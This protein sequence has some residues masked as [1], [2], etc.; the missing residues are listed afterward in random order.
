M[1]IYFE[2]DRSTAA[3]C[4]VKSV[5]EV[6][7]TFIC[8]VLSWHGKKKKTY[9]ETGQDLKAKEVDVWRI[10]HRLEFERKVDIE[11]VHKGQVLRVSLKNDMID[12]TGFVLRVDAGV[13]F[14]SQTTGLSEGEIK[15]FRLIDTDTISEIFSSP[16][17]YRLR[18]LVKGEQIGKQNIIWT[19]TNNKVAVP[20]KFE[21]KVKP[22]LLLRVP[23]DE[24]YKRA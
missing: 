10:V 5:D 14:L 9:F 19:N 22:K 18:N 16:L 20:K 12:F 4:C 8:Q 3:T 17:F 24:K 21:K 7:G 23:A 2:K 1:V 13:V 6:E 11:A 15:E